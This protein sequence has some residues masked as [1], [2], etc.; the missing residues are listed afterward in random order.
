MSKLLTTKVIQ[1]SRSMQKQIHISTISDK[2]FSADL[3]QHC[4]A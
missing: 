2:K 1:H 3:L 4:V